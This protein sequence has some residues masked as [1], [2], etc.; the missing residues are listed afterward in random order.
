MAALALVGA[1]MTGC[2]S[3]EDFADFQQPEKKGKV[4]T[5]TS[6]ISLG[7][8]AATR[9]LDASNGKKTFKSGDKIVVYYENASGEY[10][11][12]NGNGGEVDLTDI[13]ADGK[14]ASFT[15]TMTDPKPNG[16]LRYVYP[17]YLA[18]DVATD[19]DINDDN[20]TID[21]DEIDYDQYCTLSDL[22]GYFDLAVFDGT[23]TAEGEL[24][25]SATLKNKLAILAIKFKDGTTDV[26]EDIKA[27]TITDGTN[28]YEVRVD[29]GSGEQS[30]I[31]V[32]IRPTTSAN[33]T[34][35]A[36]DNISDYEMVN[37]AKYTKE[38]T[39]KTYAAGNWYNVTWQVA[40]IVS[41]DL[42]ALTGA[43]TAQSGD[44]L[45]GTTSYAISIADGAYVVLS[46]A[47]IN[48]SVICLGDA[49]I[50]LEDGTTNTIKSGSTA[51]QA[52]PEGKTLTI[53]GT[54]QLDVTTTGQ[55]ETA[56]GAPKSGSCG[57]IV[58]ENGVIN[59]TSSREA[60]AIGAGMGSSGGNSVC[61]DITINGGTVTA[62]VSGDGY[63]AGIGS[64]DALVN[65][66]ICG[67]I[68]INGG[69]V[70]ATGGNGASGIGT[71]LGEY[72]EYYERTSDSQ[73][74]KITITGGK[75]TATGGSMGSGIGAGCSA[76]GNCICGDI[77]ISGGIIISQ[78]GDGSA[79]IGSG[80]VYPQTDGV[81]QCGNITITDGDVTAAGGTYGAGIGTGTRGSDAT[82]KSK[83]GDITISGG[84]IVATGNSTSYDV[85]PES[86]EDAEVGTVTVT[87]AVKDAN[88][89]NAKIY[90]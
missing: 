62:I 84:T 33:I 12:V 35:E 14:T 60:A 55:G 38:L 51:L 50:S 4:V 65:N 58:I 21:W 6:T 81:T 11:R 31:Y 19:D 70:V 27:L 64:G 49:T 73:C 18:E 39:G 20:E 24:P 83:S 74:G 16:K 13:S 46:D 34:I 63:G 71:G 80:Y 3:D 76:S 37:P 1:V 78:G 30:T 86:L 88:G 43:Y 56:I 57:N 53:T 69:T 47:T 23:L 9:A 72:S 59:A 66:S 82:H 85:G 8:G 54:G 75:V 61:G 36:W 17:A 26:T 45:S 5:L 79:G 48:N 87:V 25:A 77:I 22:E 42:S 28:N 10:Y 29:D 67:N 44:K 68:T 7:D 32:A 89:D 41:V 15:V 40:N 52:G 90:N 2:S